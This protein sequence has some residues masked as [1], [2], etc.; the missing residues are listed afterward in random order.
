M[1]VLYS[2]RSTVHAETPSSRICDKRF[3]SLRTL[4][5][6]CK[7]WLI[8]KQALEQTATNIFANTNVH[9][10]TE[11]KKHLGAPLGS[12]S[13]IKSEVSE[14]VKEWTEELNTLSEI[15]R[16]HPHAAYCAYIHGLK[17]KWLYLTRTTPDIC[18][19]AGPLTDYHLT[20]YVENSSLQTMRSA[21]P[22]EVFP[23]NVT[24]KFVTYWLPSSLRSAMM[25]LL[26]RFCNPSQVKL[27]TNGAPPLTTTLA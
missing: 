24:M 16:I 23:P 18:G 8:T 25:W 27:S 15:A 10:T 6:G 14:Q 13:Y 9:V 22:L 2:G 17:S 5:N 4:P 26:N 20:V 12:E 19:T 21:A 7:T 3:F 11:G 1:C